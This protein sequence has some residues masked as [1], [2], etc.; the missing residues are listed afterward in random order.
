MPLFAFIVTLLLSV[1]PVNGFEID[2]AT[3]YG[4]VPL[5]AF[6]LTVGKFGYVN[7]LDDSVSIIF[8]AAVITKLPDRDEFVSGPVPLESATVAFR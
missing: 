2:I 6:I 7:E 5:T 1:K 8:G 4:G 3:E